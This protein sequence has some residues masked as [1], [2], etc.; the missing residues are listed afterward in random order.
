MHHAEEV[1]QQLHSEPCRNAR[2]HVRAVG[3]ALGKLSCEDGWG[4][5]ATLEYRV[6][7][8]LNKRRGALS[9]GSKAESVFLF[10]RT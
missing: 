5:E 2:S 10:P 3:A 9:C 7:P 8:C 4:L 1:E 6:K